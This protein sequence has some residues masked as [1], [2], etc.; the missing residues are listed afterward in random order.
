M[1]FAPI[2]QDLELCILTPFT[3]DGFVVLCYFTTVGFID[4]E[5]V[6]ANRGIDDCSFVPKCSLSMLSNA[7]RHEGL[8][9]QTK[10]ESQMK[11]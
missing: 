4:T 8:P 7:H 6:G 2:G 5:L 1:R 10:C 9:V 11:K 3:N